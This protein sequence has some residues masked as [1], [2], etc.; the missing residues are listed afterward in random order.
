VVVTFTPTSVAVLP[1][2][3]AALGSD[4]EPVLVRDDEDE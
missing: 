2:M 4:E 3:A 1:A